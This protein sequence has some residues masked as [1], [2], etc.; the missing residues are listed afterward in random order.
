MPE[1]NTALPM[2]EGF[3]LGEA[4]SEHHGIYCYPAMHAETEEKYIVKSIRVPANGTKLEALLLAGA[5]PDRAAAV[6]YFKDMANGIAQE[7]ALLQ[8]LCQ[9]EGFT[10]YDRWQIVPSEDEESFEVYLLGKYRPT[11]ERYLSRNTMTHLGAVNLGLDLCSALAGCRRSGMLYVDLKPS[12]VFICSG[13]EYRIGDLGFIPLASLQYASLPEKY[14]SDYIAPEIADA[15]SALNDTLDVYAVGRILYRIYNDGQLPEVST[16]EPLSAPAYA[17][18]EMASIILKACDPNPADRWQ[19]P[20]Q[21]GQ[22]LAHYLQSNVVNDEPIVPVVEAEE[23]EIAAVEA[24]EA[25]DPSTACILSEVN[26]ALESVGA[27][28]APIEEM[29]EDITEETDALEEMLAQA[30]ALIAHE[31]P[32]P[33]VAPAPIDVPIPTI[34]PPEV[35]PVVETEEITEEVPVIL[36]AE[37]VVEEPVEI[38]PETEETE[39]IDTE[40]NEYEDEEAPRSGKGLIIALIAFIVA[41]SL[42]I[43]GYFFYK[44]EYQQ[45]IHSIAFSGEEDVLIVTLSSNINDELLTVI[46]T[47]AYGNTKRQNVVDGVAIFTDLS[48]D[49]RYKVEVVISG[50]HE[51]VGKTTGVH[52]T[53][54]ETAIVG[55]TASSAAETGTVIVNFTVRGPESPQWIVYYSAEGEAEKQVVCVSHVAMINGLTVGKKYTF[56]VEPTTELYLVGENTVEFTPTEMIY[57][58]NLTIA[59]FVNNTLLVTWNAPE[60]ATVNGWTVRCYNDA[61][62]DKTVTVTDTSATFADLDRSAAYTVEVSA[63]GMSL[64]NRVSLAANSVTITEFTANTASPTKLPISWTFEGNAPEGGWVVKY[65]ITG[66]ADPVYLDASKPNIVI[67]PMVPGCEY[68][69]EIMTAKGDRVFDGVFTYT[70][71]QAPD[72]VGYDISADY[73]EFSMC[74]TPDKADWDRN[75][76]KASDYTQSFAIGQSASF[77]IRLNH[78]YNTSSDNIIT[79]FVIRD[80]DGNILSIDTQNRTWTS[81]WYRGYGKMTLPTMPDAIGDYTVEIFFNGQY[82]TTENFYIV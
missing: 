25:E 26:Q 6:S 44:F 22:A 63:S 20:G 72:F 55:L 71:P 37:E 61:G 34:I 78:E 67:E 68:V 1:L 21:M 17:D 58:E 24:P 13:N 41:A 14:L 27:E 60:G 4:M 11:L 43:G 62:Y 33:V 66:M 19:D 77:S 9:L 35:P 57:P 53:A 69:I 54:E 81:M 79:L 40:E 15:F 32:E 65:A 64:G 18:P 36:P 29:S 59:G 52:V 45:T 7:A 47:D 80:V 74:L 39:Y 23:V 38:Q 48:P 3:L 49:T 42:F 30:D 16:K 10:A 31:T 82:V 5:F 51:L 76:L 8:D 2:L 56:R 70:T 73:M 46:C 50:F 28:N 75:D 12:N